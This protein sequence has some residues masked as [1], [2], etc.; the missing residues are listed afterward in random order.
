MMLA[1]PGSGASPGLEAWFAYENTAL[2]GGP[3]AGL[4]SPFNTLLRGAPASRLMRVALLTALLLTAALAGCLSRSGT[5]AIQLRVSD[6]GD[7]R[8]FSSVNLTLDKVRIDARTLN[9]ETLPSAVTTLELVST[10]R[11]GPVELFRQ[12]VRADQYQKI[13]LIPPQGSSFQGI[14]LDGTKVAVI[15]PALFVQTNFEVP[16]GGTATFEFVVEVLKQ[17]TGS[18]SPTYYIVADPEAS[19]VTIS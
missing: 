13:T 1:A 12:T 9:P 16:R 11:S 2:R 7:I 5:L 15:A 19:R 18:G 6:V 4:P 17:S 8:Q 3:R 10:A 14:L